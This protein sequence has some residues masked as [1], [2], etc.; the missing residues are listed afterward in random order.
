VF[1]LVFD[2][3]KDGRLEL[4]GVKEAPLRVSLLAD[5]KPLT[6]ER[7]DAGFVVL[8]PRVPPST[9]ASVVV[10]QMGEVGAGSGGR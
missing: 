9:I 3:P 7:T 10:L 6:V 2:W 1:A 5:G 8:L 4:T